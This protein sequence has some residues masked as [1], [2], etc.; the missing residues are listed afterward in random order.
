MTESCLI[1]T[2]SVQPYRRRLCTTHYRRLLRLAKRSFPKR[3]FTETCDNDPCE[4]REFEEGLCAEHF[5]TRYDILPKSR[6]PNKTQRGCA[7]PECSRPHYGRGWCSGHLQQIN[8]GVQV[9]PLR[10]PAVWRHDGHGYLTRAVQVDGVRLVQ[11]HHRLVMEESLGRRLLPGEN[12][13]HINGVRDDN[14]I[15]NLELWSSSQPSGQRAIDKL[16]WAREIIALYEP[17]EDK[18]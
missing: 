3:H 8:R 7:A 10:G 1:R 12:V 17:D 15:E 6:G 11:L 4:E 2:C 13:H 16:K 18:L 5:I 9:G 14:R